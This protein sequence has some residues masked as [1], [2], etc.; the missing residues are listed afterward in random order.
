MLRQTLATL[1]Q[2]RYVALSI[3]MVLV[4][5][6]C[7]ALGTWQIVRF[8]E[9]VHANDELSANAHDAAVAV[10]KVLPKVGAPA[11]ATDRIRFRTITATG[12]NAKGEKINTVAVYDRK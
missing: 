1:R 3:V 4:A 10:G 11:P 9:K 6:T 5:L 7:V 8:D 12:V 2:P